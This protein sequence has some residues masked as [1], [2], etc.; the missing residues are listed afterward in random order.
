MEKETYSREDAIKILN[1]F[2]NSYS[3][4]YTKEMLHQC[5]SILE[6]NNIA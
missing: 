4:G 2:I 6:D 1:S 3:D 5:L